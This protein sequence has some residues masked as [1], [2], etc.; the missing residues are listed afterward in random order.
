MKGNKPL[1]ATIYNPQ[2]QS[3]EQLIDAFVVR[4]PL[5]KRLFK[6]L[7]E[8]S[9]ERPD[10][11]YLIIGKRGMGKTTL[12][13]RLCYEIQN[14]PELNTKLLPLVFN[15]EEYSVNRL[16]KFWERILELLE[17]QGN[18]SINAE[19]LIEEY[20]EQ[21][22]D[23]D[24]YEKAL[25]QLVKATIQTQPK[26]LVLFI[27]NVGQMFDR[28]KKYESH[29]LRKI[30][31]TESSLQ[32][33]T[34]SSRM[35][36]HFYRYEHPFYEFFKV[37][38][39][40]GLSSKETKDLLLK[41][42]EAYK[43]EEIKTVVT[44]QVGRV[45]TLRRLTGGVIRSIVLLFEIFLDNTNG[46]AFKDLEAVLDRVTP[47][48][49]HRMDDLP[50]QQQEIME[51][52]ALAWDAISTQEITKK[53]R[54]DSKKVSAQLS[55]LEK[56]DHI[57][58]IATST[59][60][61]FYQISERFFNIWY[62][63]RH[64]R[65]QDRRKVIW[66]VRF[67]EEWCSA[68]ELHRRAKKHVESLKS[69]RY[70]ERGAFYMTE[71]LAQTKGLSA[72]AQHELLESTRIFYSTKGKREY[73][74]SLSK[75]DI[76]LFE[77]A[78]GL[79][80]DGKYAEAIPLFK[81]VRDQPLRKIGDCYCEMNEYEKAEV[82]FKNAIQ[83]GDLDAKNNLA[84]LY[85]NDL[86]KLKDAEAL[87]LEAIEDG[88]DFAFYNLA[89][90]Y[91]HSLNIY[92]KAEKYYLLSIEK[93]DPDAK[94]KLANL[95]K[96]HLEKYTEAEVLY[97]EAIEEGNKHA[98]NNLANLCKDHLGKYAEAEVLYLEAIEEGDKH[99]KNN[100]G[101]LYQDQLNRYTESE[102]FYKEA[103]EEGDKHAKNNLA[104]LY[105][106]YLE[107]YAEAEVLYLEAIEEGYKH[108]KYNLAALYRDHL[109]EHNKAEELYLS[110]IND[111]HNYA[112]NNLANLYQDHLGKYQEAERLY[113]E[114]IEE[115][116]GHAK[117]GL[118]NLYAN[119]H[120]KHLEAEALYLEAI[121]DGNAN[122][123]NGLATLYAEHLEK[124]EEAEKYYLSAIEEGDKY[125]KYN[126]A[127]FY[128]LYYKKYYK[129]EKW[130]LSAIEEKYD[131][132]KNALAN[133]YRD[134]LEKYE[135]AE[136]YYLSAIEGGDKHARYNLAVLYH[137]DLKHY[138]GAEKFYLEAINDKY[139]GAK[140]AL[141]NL[142]RDHLE[143]YE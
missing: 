126:L 18:Y 129:A 31:S 105:Q 109:N 20:S 131:I 8:S 56:Q 96:N 67:L 13:L 44:Q 21:Y 140:N 10:Q 82:C 132:A 27:D 83:K 53:T 16:F 62:L 35:V 103:I 93:G 77:K 11:H 98:K 14:D 41:L 118:A 92:E 142:Y 66:L 114:A 81:E 9:T 2:N 32:L 115:G 101:N 55:Q 133:L 76:E 135:E 113:L 17:A 94:N 111:G 130:Y 87:Y 68:D 45:E 106:N 120:S 36:E 69:G 141:A 15:E 33:V 88:I 104:N 29:R 38:H 28:F 22:E 61:K 50:S 37:E 43:K 26:K 86:E 138:E 99:A 127:L 123:K 60:N 23:N 25:F 84:N 85:S 90:L 24:E 40:R 58:K 57:T 48:Y 89:I 139:I 46:N 63:M 102:R 72:D 128:E 65:V 95:Y 78:K 79:C 107:K 42:G 54:L 59:K 112:K 124:Y 116:N 3:K 49:K 51:A 143:K 73:L 125:A 4:I 7:K 122:A 91:E 30:L 75:S 74:D 100:L 80:E 70:D 119:H 117:N 110:A 108:A 136:R 12:L 97:L 134:H 71:A 64:G 1:V 121:V 34:A 39:L 19:Q 52:V 5:F 137:Y 47:L 6:E